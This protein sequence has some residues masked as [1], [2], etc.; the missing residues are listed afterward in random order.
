MTLLQIALML[1]FAFGLGYCTACLFMAAGG[2]EYSP[3]IREDCPNLM[4]EVDKILED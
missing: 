1:F 4:D 2:R 3:D